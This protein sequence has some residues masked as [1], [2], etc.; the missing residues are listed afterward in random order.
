MLKK[1]CAVIE[2]KENYVSDYIRI[3]REAWPEILKAIQESGAENLIV[4]NYKNLSILFYECEDID[5]FYKV[6]SSKEIT[7]KWND[8]VFP[9]FKESP[10]LDGTANVATLEKIMDVKQ[11]LNGKLEAF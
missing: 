2:L 1:Y 6:Y 10:V 9:W 11:Q 7:K 3:H 4:Y 8:T 5:Q